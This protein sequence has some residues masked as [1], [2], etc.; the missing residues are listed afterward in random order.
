MTRL[1]DEGMVL[2]GAGTVT[3]SHVLGTIT[4]HLLVNPELLLILQEELE[5]VRSDG[6]DLSAEALLVRLEH[7]PYLTAT[8][9]E[10]LRI[11][12]GVVHRLERVAPD[13]AL[14]YKEWIIPPKTATGMTPA[15]FHVDPTF[16]PAPLEFRP[17]RWLQDDIGPSK[18]VFMPFGKGTRMCLG[19]NLAY[20][21]LYLTLAAVLQR[22]DLQL[23]ETTRADI[24][25]VHDF[26]AGKPRLDSKG[27]RVLV[28]RRGCGA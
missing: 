3:T 10:G 7:L 19:L 16:F 25:V 18:R 12:H 23:F 2:I 8:I 11:G 4:Y 21:E 22:F 17:E 14:K 28:H 27:V 6:A 20:A 24:D 26:V 13:R 5:G 1:V 15:I 9:A